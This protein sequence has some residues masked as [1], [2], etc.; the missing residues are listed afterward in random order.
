MHVAAELR[1]RVANTPAKPESAIAPPNLAQLGVVHPIT[2]PQAKPAQPAKPGKDSR[3]KYMFPEFA[4]LGA[5]AAMALCMAFVPSIREAADAV[6][7]ALGQAKEIGT[8]IF[9]GA[10]F[11]V[12]GA[13]ALWAI[14]VRE[15]GFKALAAAEAKAKE[16]VPAI[17]VRKPK[18]LK[19]PKVE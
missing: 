8:P 9:A 15:Q 10:F 13:L 18:A 17:H 6:V 11:T 12:T 14:E 1:A 2:A 16:L 7:T 19:V 3:I 5:S 4:V